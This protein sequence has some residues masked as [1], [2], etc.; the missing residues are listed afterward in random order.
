M[1]EITRYAHYE[2]GS[3]KLLGFY[4]SDVHGSAI[5]EPNFAITE[6]QWY[7]ALSSGANKVS[8]LF[9]LFYEPPVETPE[10]RIEIIVIR[11]QS[12]MDSKAREYGYDN[13]FTAVTYADEPLVP[14]FQE[15]GVAFRS[16]R[17]AVWAHC[18]D[19]LAQWQAGQLSDLTVD[20][21][22]STLPPFTPPDV[23]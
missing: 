15:E 12:H 19:L 2:E 11:V 3:N 5:P 22:I 16:W 9:E 23:Q 18:Y 17:S 10:E 7:D 8:E 14:K 20:D 21:V 6:Q 1:N 4:S 13:V